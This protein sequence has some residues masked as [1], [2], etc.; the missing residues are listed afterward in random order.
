M[1]QTACA[2]VFASFLAA[3]LP[4]ADQQLVNMVMPDAKIVAGINVDTARN[5]PLGTFLMNQIATSDPSFQKFV[6]AM[7]FNPRTDLQEVLVATTG[8]PATAAPA[9]TSGDVRRS[10]RPV[11]E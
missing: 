6:D 8:S 4:G 3:S 11:P 10:P 5:S 7:G 2:V 9:G 1:R